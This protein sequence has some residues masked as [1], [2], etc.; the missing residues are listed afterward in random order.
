MPNGPV[1]A[2]DLDIDWGVSQ[3]A[4]ISAQFKDIAAPAVAWSSPAAGISEANVVTLV[5]YITDNDQIASAVLKRAGFPA[6]TLKLTDGRYE[7]AGIRL[8]AGE[9]VVVIEAK[10]LS[11]NATTN[12]TTLVWNTGSILVVGDARDTSEGQR[13]EFPIQLKSV[14][15][16]SGLSFNLRYA[17]YVDFLADPEFVA[18]GFL[19]GGLI[20]LNTNTLASSGSPWRRRVSVSRPA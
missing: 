10:D 5:G 15:S 8:D 2:T 4:V 11:G 20:T 9:N 19:P 16:L 18:S 3:S 1:D 17:D 12:Q 6:Q 7:V 13:V 14:Q